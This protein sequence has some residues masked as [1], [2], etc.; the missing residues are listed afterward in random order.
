ML[1]F[2]GT[3]VTVTNFPARLDK[4]T[5]ETIE[6]RTVVQLLG[7]R[8]APDGQWMSELEDIK[9]EESAKFLPLRG[10]LIRMVVKPW[11]MNGRTGLSAAKGVDIQEVK[12]EA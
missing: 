4:E 7:K 5:G 12:G 6:A 8:P 9:V 3:V 10:K 11:S 1:T 2:T